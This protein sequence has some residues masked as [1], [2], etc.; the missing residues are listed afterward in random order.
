MKGAWRTR[1]IAAMLVLA[2]FGGLSCASGRKSTERPGENA[3]SALPP[4]LPKL[5]RAFLCDTVTTG[6]GAIKPGPAREGFRSSDREVYLLVRL[7]DVRGSHDLTF[8]WYGPRDE[9]Y[10]DSEPATIAASEKSSRDYAYLWHG[11]YIDGEKASTLHGG[12]KAVAVLDGAPL[13]TIPFALTE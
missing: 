8:K 6:A 10:I 13:V 2:A 12:W 9:L 7:D 5:T 4:P 3:V 1:L 11:I